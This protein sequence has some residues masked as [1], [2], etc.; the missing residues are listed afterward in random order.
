[1]LKKTG[2]ISQEQKERKERILKATDIVQLIGEYVQLKPSGKNLIGLCPFHQE[3]T[4][5][6]FVSHSYQN[7]KCYGCG[8]Y[9]DAIRFVMGI[10]NLQFIEALQFLAKRCGISIETPKKYSSIVTSNSKADS[11]LEKS[12]DFF[13]GNL[14]NA[15]QTSKIW[16]YL[17]KRE[18]SKELI[19]KFQLGYVPSGWTNLN[20]HLSGLNFSNSIQENAGL[21]KKGD[22]G[23]YY[24]RLRNR[25]I[26][27]IK[28][29]RGILLGF[30]GRA[31][32][33]EEPKYLNPPETDSYKK[34][35][36]FYGIDLAYAQIRRKRRAILVEGYLDVIR[37][38]E[39]EWL[40]SIA[41]CGTALT[42]E[43]IGMLKL[44]GVE[45]AIL[46]FDGDEAGIKA[47]ERSAKLF[48]EN[49]LD[50]RVMILPEG[51]DP[52]D[53]FKKFS[54]KDFEHLLENA[55]YD[56]D[57]IINRIIQE[58]STKGKTY[59]ESKI[60]EV[61]GLV[62]SIESTIKRDL[63]LSNAAKSF[64][65]SK[66][67]LQQIMNQPSVRRETSNTQPVNNSFPIF[68][69][70]QM[71]EVRFLQYLMNHGEAMKYARDRVRINDFVSDELSEIFARFLQLNNNEFALLNA[72]DFPELFVEYSTKLVYMLHNDFEYK[73]PVFVRPGS[74]ELLKLKEENEKKNQTFSEE[75][76]KRLI[77]ELKKNRDSHEKSK[78]RYK[79]PE[80]QME[81][82]RLIIENRK[83]TI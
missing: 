39:K 23:G 21:I 16:E 19:E 79:P 29:K 50:C 62:N 45:E 15:R 52:D 58:F 80:Q 2:F 55:A 67:K 74:E 28:D 78:M 27:P 8:E 54:N 22:K 25:L 82:L 47:A 71:P 26:F 33:D 66:K 18:V 40:E 7:F 24:D 75:T 68:E 59:R 81:T 34:S 51:L 76:L 9:G 32:G 3:K 60:R 31:I 63:F 64:K 43:H 53:Y 41:T 61:V 44:L 14:I 69:K 37:L 72:Q 42:K 5:S 6:F 57:F 49:D 1:M 36:V 20:Q 10:E 12:L 83:K 13:H 30:A 77:K 11:C 4:P 56:L 46:L 35:S 70:E 38:H 48:I 17:R 73:G 65:I